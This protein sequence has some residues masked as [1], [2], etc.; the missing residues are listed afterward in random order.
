MS[1]GDQELDIDGVAR[2]LRALLIET[3]VA[4]NSHTFFE[5]ASKQLSPRPDHLQSAPWP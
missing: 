4:T 5:A 1:S 3:G 2:R